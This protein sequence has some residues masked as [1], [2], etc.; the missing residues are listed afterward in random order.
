MEKTDFGQESVYMSTLATEATKQNELYISDFCYAVQISVY[1]LKPIG[2]WPLME[3]DVSLYKIVL[4]KLS[5]V[6]TTFL[7]IFTV[8]PWI[9][10]IVKEKWDI[11]LILRTMCPLIFSL[12]I[13]ARYV[14]LLWH[15][16]RLKTCVDR[17][18]DDW[19]H[20]ILTQD[21]EIMLVNARLGRIFGIVSVAFMYSCGILYYLLPLI[22]P[23][24]ITEDNVT[25][26]F[27][28]SPCEFLVFNSK[29]SPAYEIVYCIQCLAGFTFYSA[30][31][32]IC[33]L[34]AHFVTHICG[35]CD[36]L[37]SFLEEIV[38]GGEHNDG[39]ID[40]RIANA[41]SRHLRLLKLVSKVS[42]LFTEICL[43]EFINASCNICLLGYY[44]I[45]VRYMILVNKLKQLRMVF[46]EIV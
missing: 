16:D 25:I 14:L 1:L 29:D 15:Q 24:M 27:H 9:V 36:V 34:M 6:I 18:A 43:M 17:V 28:P 32:G 30:F 44:I 26:R 3:K 13:F 7:Q 39:S 8:V 42:G 21:R 40:D 19:R 5:M 33:S 38:I 37:D 12:T 4:H 35:Q 11:M 10:L 22:L 46:N 2:A 41:I 20:T 31:C 23:N 45:T